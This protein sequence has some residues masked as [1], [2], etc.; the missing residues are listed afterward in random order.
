MKVYF[1]NAATSVV[2]DSVIELM[3]KTM[4]EDYANPSAKH[5]MGIDAERYVREAASRIAS[6]LKCSEKE[7]I[8]TSCGTESNNMA[9]IGAALARQ[10]AGKHIITTGIEHASV[11]RPLDFL[12][13][14]GFELSVL[15]VDRYGHVDKD[16]LKSLIRPDTIL[17]STMLVNNEIGAVEPV[18]EI[19]GIIK[20]VNP[21][22]LYHVDAIQA[23]GKMRIYPGRM[24]IDML[25][26]SGHKFHGPKGVGFLYIRDGV[27]IKPILYGGGQQSDMRSGTINVPGIAG[28]GLAA[29]EAYDSLDER[30][31]QM[32]AVRNHIIEAATDIEGVSV[33][34]SAGDDGAPHIVSISVAGVR[35]EVLLHALEARQIYVSSGSACSSHHPGISGTLKG[36]GLKSDLLDSTIRVSLDEHNTIEQADY[37]IDALK[38]EIETLRKYA[39]R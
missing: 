16:E 30:V 7:I 32:K 6:T 18:E 11:Y 22:T 39:R 4:R 24:G 10:R 33:N 20:S 37:F 19:S 26:V 12:T 25:S 9:L 27:H 14:L 36:I 21:N 13:E 1:D 35:A 17:V 3:V 2:S 34:S 8:F 29:K 38:K 23:Y 15:S 5:T 31:A 28:M